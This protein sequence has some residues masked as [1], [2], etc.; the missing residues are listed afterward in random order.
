MTLIINAS[1][2]ISAPHLFALSYYGFIS[3]SMGLTTVVKLSTCICLRFCKTRSS[4][5][6]NV[7]LMLVHMPGLFP[8]WGY[9]TER[10]YCNI[11]FFIYANFSVFQ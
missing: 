6:G 4:D 10:N 11:N 3:Q 1:S 7:F 5:N 8:E 2:P 9:T